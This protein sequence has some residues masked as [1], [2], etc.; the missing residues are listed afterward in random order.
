M[1]LLVT[2][3]PRLRLRVRV[4]FAPEGR[5]AW[6]RRG[7][8]LIVGGATETVIVDGTSGAELE[9]WPRGYVAYAAGADDSWVAA[10]TARGYIDLW[11]FGRPRPGEPQARHQ[12]RITALA[13]S[14]DERRIFT[15]G[16]DGRLGIWRAA[17]LDAA[18]FGVGA[19]ALDL[20]YDGASDRVAVA[21]GRAGVCILDGTRGVAVGGMRPPD[22]ATAV[23][24]AN[25]I[26]FAGT[27]EGQ[28][29]AYDAGRLEPLR[30]TQPL[31]AGAIARIV[32]LGEVVAVEGAEALVILGA[33]SGR[34][35]LRWRHGA[36]VA[37]GS[38]AVHGGQNA[39]AIAV[40]AATAI[41]ELDLA[42]LGERAAAPPPASSTA[43]TAVEVLA[44]YHPGD[45]ALAG[46]VV[47]HLEQAGARVID[48]WRNGGRFVEAARQQVTTVV[49]YGPSG[50]PPRHDYQ[51][52][53]LETHGARVV[54]VILP[55][56]V[57]PEEKRRFHGAAY[58][59]FH[60]RVQD[61]DALARV[62]R[63]VLPGL[64][65]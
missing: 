56:G 8:R 46:A 43:P 39:L 45:E 59:C 40:P 28:L 24:W 47:A 15:A 10:A 21:A 50:L 27:R 33:Q 11:R 18:F 25:G 57:V 31:G 4:P 20:A 49:L 32:P 58:V 23:A 52:D 60:G 5:M 64:A 29:A 63:A 17:T 12:G 51:L 30:P 54:P 38:L 35:I 6:T 9:R 61:A 34:E 14:D 7:D 16:E 3:P 55:G 44:I 53:V 37:G 1:T 13:F 26:V 65:R 62:S 48:G 42:N 2:L 19:R 41:V 22:R 36:A